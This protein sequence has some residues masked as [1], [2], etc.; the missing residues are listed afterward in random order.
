MDGR[1]MDAL[2]I[3]WLSDF[4]LAGSG[5]FNIS[6]PL[7]QGLINKGHEVKAIGLGYKG[8]EHNYN[9]GIIPAPS[10]KEAMAI[11]QNLSQ[12]W[13]FDIFV[14]ALDITIQEQILKSMVNRN[15]GYIG[16][17]PIEADPLCMSWA[18]VLMQMDK[19]FIISQFGTD[20]ALK[21]N[22]KAE[23]LEIGIDTDQ[24]RIPSEEERKSLRVSYGIQEDEF[25]VLTVADNQERKNLSRSMEIFAAVAK[26]VPKSRYILVTRENSFVGWKLR[27]LGQV[28]K[29]NN[30]FNIYERGMPFEELWKLYAIS[31]AFLLTSKAEG[32]G[33]PLLEAQA[34]G[35]PCVA[36]NCTAIAELLGEDRGLLIDADYVYTDP[37]GNGHRYFASLKDGIKKL[38]ELSTFKHVDMIQKA[39]EYVEAKDWSITVEDMERA[40]LA[41]RKI[42]NEQK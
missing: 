33:M 30:K 5:Y 3:V 38:L 8:K 39:R 35:V 27:D 25:V 12:L 15:F 24:W 6:I 16:I 2:R 42:P 11:L 17:M 10:M 14:V 4:D 13:K 20:E 22:V 37:F 41:A 7:C 34:V 23:H 19:V 28:L 29:I 1:I 9:F 32:L 36:T 26:K 40:A 31:D 18:M 21:M